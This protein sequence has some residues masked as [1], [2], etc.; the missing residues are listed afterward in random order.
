MGQTISFSI[1]GEPVAKG[2]ARA[3]VRNGRVAHYT[4]EDTASYES[5][6]KLAAAKAMQEAGRVQPITG[7][8]AL[9]CAFWLPVPKSYSKK[10]VAACLAG[11]EQHCKRPDADN[12]LKAVKDG[13]NAV[14]WHDD[15]QVVD[16][17]CVKGYA[18]SPCAVIEIRELVCRE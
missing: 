13:C 2:R 11:L 12:L 16:V 1:P 8:V 5:L 10:R 4:P 14:V 9:F 18:A 7:A 15:C 3:Y 17:R 6:V